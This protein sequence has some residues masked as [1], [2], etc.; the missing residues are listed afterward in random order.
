MELSNKLSSKLSNASDPIAAGHCRLGVARCLAIVVV[1]AAFYSLTAQRGVS[2]QDS[3]RFQYRVLRGEYFDDLGLALAHPLYIGGGRVLLWLGGEK[4]LPFLLNAF[5]GLG[6][7][8]AL[9]LFACV[10]TTLTR[11]RWIG[12]LAA[13]MLGVSHTVWWLA[14]IAEVYT[15]SVAVLAGELLLLASLLRQ[16]RPATLAGLALLS[17]LGLCVHNFALL[18]LPVYIVVA[19]V[20]VVRKR[21][22]VWS[23]AVAAGAYVLGAGLYLTMIVL[24][25]MREGS[26]MAAVSSALVGKYTAAVANVAG[27]SKHGKENALLSAMNFLNPLLLLAAV[28]WVRFRRRLGG[29][30]A[31][32]LGA[33]TLI[34]VVFFIR[35]PVPDQFTFILPSLVMITLAAAVGLAVLADAGRTLRWVVVGL[36]L[37]SLA[38]QPMFYAAGP[39]LATRFRGPPPQRH[40]F[41]DEWRYWLTPWKQNENSAEQF[42]RAVCENV[43]PSAIVILDTTALPPLQVY[44]LTIQ[45]QQGITAMSLEQFQ[46]LKD[47]DPANYREWLEQRPLYIRPVPSEDETTPLFGPATFTPCFDGVL[48]RVELTSP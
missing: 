25:A 36:C 22:P 39:K 30:L 6:M 26:L 2:W 47:N 1:F 48:Y 15:W 32:A 19:I 33:I 38:A 10:C 29:A 7:A 31:A 46:S 21:L 43:E 34:E 3:G 16:P 24:L 23:L 37:L 8:V 40:A 44:L 14:T 9:G 45:N 17:G 5:S 11:R 41:R 12:V 4:A 35:Y 27:V 42:C 20:L 13:A 28:G 18:P